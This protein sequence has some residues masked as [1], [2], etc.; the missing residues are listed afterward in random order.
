M[1]TD[2]IQLLSLRGLQPTTIFK[3]QSIYKLVNYVHGP[4]KSVVNV[5]PAES[6]GGSSDRSLGLQ[7]SA[8][9][10]PG[11]LT[12]TKSRVSCSRPIP[13]LENIEHL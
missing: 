1:L 6:P 4:S 7:L 13:L 9:R 10:A 8:A 12:S 11:T 5:S 2:Q 3:L